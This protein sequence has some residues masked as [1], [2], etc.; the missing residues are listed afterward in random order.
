MSPE[1]HL[2]SS[3]ASVE[4]VQGAGELPRLSVASVARRLGVAPGTLRTWDRRY[5]LGPSGHQMGEHRKYSREDL[6]RL[7]YMHKL[8]ISGVSPASAA[9]LA[10]NYEETNPELQLRSLIQV[11]GQLVNTLLRAAKALDYA[12]IEEIIRGQLRSSGVIATWS[13][14]LVPVLGLMGDEWERTGGGIASEHLLSEVIKKVLGEGMEISTPQNE[15]PVLVAC[16][17][18]ELHS[19]GITALAAALGELRIQI[20]FLGAR[21]PIEVIHDVARRTAPAAIFLWAQ[22]PQ[23][24]SFDKAGALPILRPAP[25]ILLGGPGWKGVEWNG[26]LIVPDLSTA[27]REISL[28]LGL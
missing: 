18:E 2:L 14:L 25:R 17:G 27:C 4:P 21:T 6:A 19:L 15:I 7:L 10:Q 5:G 9:Q 23:H 8:V 11:D 1:S 22:L 12:E 24:A 13:D 26:A 16:V 3:G 28:A 20:Q